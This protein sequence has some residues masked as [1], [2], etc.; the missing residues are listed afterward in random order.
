MGVVAWRSLL[1]WSRRAERRMGMGIPDIFGISYVHH[2]Q[3]FYMVYILIELTMQ[4]TYVVHIL[5]TF[6]RPA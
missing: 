6:H 1:I 4:Y 3:L 5:Y 2:V